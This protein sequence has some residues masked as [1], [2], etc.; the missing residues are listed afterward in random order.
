[1]TKRELIELLAGFGD[2]TIVVKR[3]LNDRAAVLESVQAGYCK[4]PGDEPT[5]YAVIL[6]FDH[7]WCNR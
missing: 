2:D 1:M 7:D 5:E 3:C 6:T 4:L